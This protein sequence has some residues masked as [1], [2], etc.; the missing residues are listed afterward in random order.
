MSIGII[1]LV[2]I[3][4]VVLF[5][6]FNMRN[7]YECNNL[8]SSSAYVT[9]IKNV[10]TVPCSN[11]LG[12]PLGT[13][14]A[15]IK[16]CE[17]NSS[18]KQVVSVKVGK[19]FR[20]QMCASESKNCSEQCCNNCTCPG[21]C[22]TVGATNSSN[23]SLMQSG[24]N[25]VKKSKFSGCVQIIENN[26][27]LVF[28][29][30]NAALSKMRSYN[31]KRDK[32]IKAN[33]KL[34]EKDKRPVPIEA[35]S[36]TSV[37][38]NAPGSKDK[39]ALCSA[40]ATGVCTADQVCKSDCSDC[41]LT[42]TSPTC[43]IPIEF[44]QTPTPIPTDLYKYAPEDPLDTFESPFS[45]ESLT[46]PTVMLAPAGYVYQ[47]PQYTY[48]EYKRPSFVTSAPVDFQDMVCNAS[49]SIPQDRRKDELFYQL[50]IP[51]NSTF[52]FSS[53]FNP[54]TKRHEINLKEKLA[55]L[56]NA[57]ALD[58]AAVLKWD[59]ITRFVIT[60]TTHVNDPT[61]PLNI[62]L[63]VRRDPNNKLPGNWA[64]RPLMDYVE[65]FMDFIFTTNMSVEHPIMTWYDSHPLNP[66]NTS[67]LVGMYYM[68]L[69]DVYKY[70]EPIFVNNTENVPFTLTVTLG[71]LLGEPNYIR[72][73]RKYKV[74]RHENDYFD[75]K[76][77]ENFI[78]LNK[79]VF[80]MLSYGGLYWD[81]IGLY[82]VVYCDKQ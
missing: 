16:A 34:P 79:G 78:M 69:Y 70:I 15:A 61:N 31:T 11:P 82:N 40:P 47:T 50:S 9:D 4:V 20:Y 21:D 62:K 13:L 80:Y 32:I 48:S 38:G 64:K 75:Q 33:L 46:T 44:T 67:D 5:I 71:T 36:V 1:A 73:V 2:V 17:K 12:R 6:V 76:E 57:N 24:A 35:V 42:C 19:A 58:N 53:T 55:I 3:A 45:Y 41:D 26:K 14:T 28:S 39:F 8:Q 22:S 10:I 51:T 72:T 68:L 56:L 43:R 59:V 66:K 54:A 74:N 52:T 60:N 37:S 81:Y 23:A 49:P 7:R 65:N 27:A 29:T 77:I 63:S 18:C 25:Y 30:F